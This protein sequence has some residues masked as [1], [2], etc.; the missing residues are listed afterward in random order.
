MFRH[1]AIHD[2]LY[3]YG[4]KLQWN[5]EANLNTKD[6]YFM[7]YGPHDKEDFHEQFKQLLA[8]KNGRI[9]YESPKAVNFNYDF[10]DGR[11][12]LVV[13]EFDEVSV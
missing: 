10:D 8:E 6:T 2:Y 7:I 1:G 3:T 4:P 9:L 11:N 12:T 13:F 5:I